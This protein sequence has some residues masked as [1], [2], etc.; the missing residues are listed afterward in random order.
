MT[1]IHTKTDRELL[2]ETRTDVAWLIKLFD[3]HIAAHRKVTLLAVGAIL[4]SITAI[5]ISLVG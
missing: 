2:I 3:E 1:D 5:L 4:S